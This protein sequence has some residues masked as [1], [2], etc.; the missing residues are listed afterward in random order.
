M[1]NPIGVGWGSGH[2]EFVEGE[3]KFKLHMR[4]A[5][6]RIPVEDE[7]LVYPYLISTSQVALCTNIKGSDHF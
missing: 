4:I 3:G 2:S 1:T 5:I 7:Y 6:S